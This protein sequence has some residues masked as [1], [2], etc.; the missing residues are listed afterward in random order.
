MENLPSYPIESVDN[1]LQLL[2]LLRRDGQLRV[3]VAADELGIARSTAHRLLA[4]LRY[5]GFV[6][7]EK[8]RSYRPGPAFSGLGAADQRVSLLGIARPYLEKLGVDVAETINLVVRQDSDVR[9][10]DCVESTQVLRVG[11]RVGVTLPAFRTSGG[12]TLLCELSRMQIE[13]LHPQFDDD[14]D[15]MAALLRGLAS[16][17]KRGYGTNFEESETG[18]TALGVAVRDAHG[19]PVAAVTIS[20]PTVRYRR[21][22]ILTLLPTLRACAEQIRRLLV[23]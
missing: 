1:V 10:V 19:A 12:K 5:R 13:Q 4:M 16:T 9:F 21:T 14:P 6:V 8:G 17:R 18:V 3:S 15:T 2:L 11:N 23:N 20:A 7:Q 22:Q